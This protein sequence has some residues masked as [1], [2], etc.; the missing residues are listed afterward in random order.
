MR[1]NSFNRFG[2]R[3]VGS[4]ETTIHDI[5]GESRY[6]NRIYISPPGN[7]PEAQETFR[8]QLLLASMMQDQFFSTARG[9]HVYLAGWSDAM[10][11]ETQL[12]GALWEPLDTTLH[13]V[14]LNVDFNPP[15][16]PAYVHADQFTWVALERAGLS[17]DLAP[18]NA[19]MQSGD[20][21]V[22][23]FMPLPDAVLATVDRLHIEMNLGTNSRFEI[24]IE[25]W[26]WDSRTWQVI[27]LQQDDNRTSVR[28]IT[29][30]NPDRYLGAQNAVQVRVSVDDTSG[31]LRIARLA[32]EQE[33]EF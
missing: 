11:L 25:L 13:L 26:D 21:V 23:Q 24:P 17:P 32:I 18:V 5:M 29:L 14:K 30:R 33:G 6:N 4:S 15:A 10:P 31:F 7:T 19:V 2:S 22:F 16:V 9:N 27:D 28:R 1:L 8:R 12:E 3:D 20:A